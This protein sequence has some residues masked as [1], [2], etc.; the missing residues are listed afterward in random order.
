MCSAYWTLQSVTFRCPYCGADNS[1]DLQTHFMGEPGS[2]LNYYRMGQPVTELRGI[3]AATVQ[4]AQGFIGKCD[5]CGEY[6]EFGADIEFGAVVK[7]WPVAT[8]DV[9]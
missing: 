7:V 8:E 4:P 6:P 3:G 5:A 1:G 2:C 9:S